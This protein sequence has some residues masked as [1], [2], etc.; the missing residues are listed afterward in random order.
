MAIKYVQ[1]GLLGC[2][3]LVGGYKHFRGM[4]CLHLSPED[5][6]CILLQY[7]GTHPQPHR[8]SQPRRHSGKKTIFCHPLTNKELFGKS[9]NIYNFNFAFITQQ[10]HAIN[11]MKVLSNIFIVGMQFAASLSLTLINGKKIN[12]RS[13]HTISESL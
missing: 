1:S 11:C 10:S 6:G 9:T 8:V 7:V 3:E 12:F 4:Q 2:D 13:Y 5:G